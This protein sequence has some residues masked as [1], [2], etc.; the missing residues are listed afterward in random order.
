[1]K[2]TIP[3]A[4]KIISDPRRTSPPPSPAPNAATKTAFNAEG[5]RA[6]ADGTFT[7]YD[8]LHGKS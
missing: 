5:M 2:T 3:V 7:A 1:M 4:N 6:N 8:K